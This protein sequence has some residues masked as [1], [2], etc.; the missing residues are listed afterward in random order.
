MLNYIRFSYDGQTKT[1]IHSKIFVKFAFCV[2]VLICL[3]MPDTCS[4]FEC[5]NRSNRD[6][7]KRFFR[8]PK[9]IQH[10]GKKCEEISKRRRQKWLR[11]LSL[12][13]AGVN[14]SNA[15]VCSDHFVKGI[16]QGCFSF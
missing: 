14:T 13:S 4:V 7:G 16:E 9:E 1:K 6:A 12:S 5:S 10:K 3:T 8:I 15:R 2:G 11:N